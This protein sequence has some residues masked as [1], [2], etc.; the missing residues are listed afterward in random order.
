MAVRGLRPIPP[1]KRQRFRASRQAAA[2]RREPREVAAGAITG[3]RGTTAHTAQASFLDRGS[4]GLTPRMRNP[5]AVAVEWKR[6]RKP[7]SVDA[8]G[9]MQIA[10][11]LRTRERRADQDRAVIRAQIFGLV[12]P[13]GD[14]RPEIQTRRYRVLVEVECRETVGRIPS[15]A[16]L[17]CVRGIE[18]VAPGA[19]G[20]SPPGP[21]VGNALAFE[22]HSSVLSAIELEHVAANLEHCARLPAFKQL[23]Q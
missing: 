13:P 23:E 17:P 12:G 21:A 4:D 6:L 18:R 15:T 20:D 10:Y 9:R 11:P 22:R 1:V 16:A 19:V 2:C 14:E 7:G 5:P 8:F 3:L